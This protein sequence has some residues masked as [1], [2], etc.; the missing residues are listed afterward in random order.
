M[1]ALYTGLR[2]GDVFALHWDDIDFARNR[3]EV[4]PR[5]TARFKRRVSVPMHRAL[6]DYLFALERQ[7]EKVVAAPPARAYFAWRLCL[8]RA[9]VKRE[10]ELTTFHSLRHTFATWIREAG[11]DKGEQ[12]LLGGWSNVATANRYDHAI[13]RLADVVKRLPKV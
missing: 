12:M 7:G 10:G 9:G 2:Q 11:A 6:A 13:D 4:E 8:K 5:K 1:I 3:I